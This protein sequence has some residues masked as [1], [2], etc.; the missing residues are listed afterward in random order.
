MILNGSSKLDISRSMLN[1]ILNLRNSDET[2]EDGKKHRKSI[3]AMI[4]VGGLSNLLLKLGTDEK[5]GIDPNSVTVRQEEYGVNELEDVT[6]PTY[7]ELIWEALKDP[8]MLMLLASAVIQFL[9]AC[10]P[11]TRDPCHADQIAWQEPFVILLSVFIVSNVAAGT[12]YTKGKELRRMKEERKH[13]N[14][15]PVYRNGEIVALETKDIVVG[16]LVSLTVG[17][18]IPCDGHFVEGNDVEVDESPLTGEPIAIKKTLEY[19]ENSKNPWMIGGTKMVKGNCSFVVMAVGPHS[20]VGKI[21]MQ[22]LGLTVET[23]EGEDAVK[24]DDKGVVTTSDD[25]DSESPLT[26]KL[27]KMAFDITKFG[28]AAAIFGACIAAIIWAILKFG[29]GK[30]IAVEDSHSHTVKQSSS[31]FS[32]ED[33]EDITLEQNYDDDSYKDTCDQ[34]S[35]NDDPAKIVQLFVTAV[36]ILVVAIPEGLPLAVTLALAVSQASMAK[37]NNMVKVLESCETMG[38]AT[39]ICSDKTGTLT[40]NRMTVT[41]LYV[42]VSSDKCGEHHAREG[43]VSV[44]QQLTSSGADGGFVQ[45]MRDSIAINS[46]DTSNL[47]PHKNKDGSIDTSRAY[48]QVGNKTECGF[49]GLCSDLCDAGTTYEDIRKSPTFASPVQPGPVGRNNACKFPFSSER[50]RMSWITPSQDGGFRLHCKGASEV[51]LARCTNVLTSDANEV[52]PLTDQHLKGVNDHIQQFANEANRTLVMA[53]RDFPPDFADWEGIYEGDGADLSSTTVDYEV[54]HGLTFVGLIGIEDPLRDDVPDSIRLCF[55]A[56]VDVRMVTGD[57]LRTAIAIASRCGILREEHFHHLPELRKEAK[58]ASY[59]K[60]LDENFESIFTLQAEMR[61]AGM[62][63]EETELFAADSKGARGRNLPS[64]EYTSDPVKA[65][66]D[67]FAMEGSDFMKK[68]AV[69]PIPHM[70]VD[71]E[72]SQSSYGKTIG[73]ERNQAG[74]V[75]NPEEFDAIW[76]SLRVMARC[77]PDDKLT[78]VQ[79][80]MESELY[81]MVDK[82]KALKED[83]GI[84]IYPDAQVVAVTGDGTNDAPALKRANVGF[85]M[86][87]TGTQ[88]A[89]DACDI[90]LMDD[91]FSSIIT[92][93]KYGRNVYE[94]VQKFIQFQLTVN[95]VAVSLAIIGAIMFQSSPLGAVQM[96]WVNLIMDSLASLALATEPPHDALLNRPPTGRND[97]IITKQ[98]W[99]NMIGQSIYQLA[100]TLLI[101]FYGH[102]MFYTDADNIDTPSDTMLVKQQ[103]IF[104]DSPDDQLRLGWFTGCEPS[105]HYSVLFNAFV[106]MTLFN[107]FASRKL[108]GEV[109]FFDGILG[110][111][112]FIVLSVIEFVLQFFFVQ[113]IGSVVGCYPKGL[114]GS[115]WGYSLLFG[116]VGWLWQLVINYVFSHV[117]AAEK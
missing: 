24:S 34:F 106:M 63:D 17:D 51:V 111:K 112:P 81:T 1:N 64:G 76:P 104:S 85:A 80:L 55:N 57:N 113:F 20:T 45:T 54:E 53:I 31:F 50:K 83:E 72:A 43:P 56:G 100:A 28:F 25:D 98:M 19:D 33:C 47:M 99:F 75:V 15:L 41:N 42:G 90:I 68:V 93:I 74:I 107:Q 67:N 27:E 10:I 32:K 116:F 69:G 82:V 39:T 108:Y 8:I 117:K 52:V 92:A 60:R 12:D 7:L 88:V 4:D 86:G 29:M 11:A 70:G 65:L 21:N 38:S 46:S 44:G 95:I 84:T 66:R 110:N 26:K 89:Q 23:D 115:Q 22:V 97:S 16:D 73:A 5:K 6:P 49:L 36:T 14:K 102:V 59:A 37:L 71:G 103:E 13:M 61:A 30:I 79:G 78:L 18:I 114:T 40:Q 87:I 77:Q 2:G 35:G 109:N 62:T 48:E 101:L 96:L 58:F 91:N 105:Q 9:L 94:S 3:Q